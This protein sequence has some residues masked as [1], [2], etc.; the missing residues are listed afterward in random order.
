M[1]RLGR[2][3]VAAPL[4]ARDVASDARVVAS[5]QVPNLAGDADH[6]GCRCSVEHRKK[7]GFCGAVS[8]IFAKTGRWTRLKF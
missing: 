3:E 4:G 2:A 6:W 7:Y 8:P 5:V 1:G